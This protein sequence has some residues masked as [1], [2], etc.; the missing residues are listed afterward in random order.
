MYG[1]M[2]RSAQCVM[3]D[4]YLE[5]RR[6]YIIHLYIIHVLGYLLYAI[7]RYFL[8]KSGIIYI[9]FKKYLHNSNIC[10]KFAPEKV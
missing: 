5:R 1:C 6:S 10:C 9:I 8:R 4:A 7:F 2:M 3:L